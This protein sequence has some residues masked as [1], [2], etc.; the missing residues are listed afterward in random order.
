MKIKSC[1][2]K[3]HVHVYSA[4]LDDDGF[5]FIVAKLLCCEWSLMYLF[6]HYQLVLL[7]VAQVLWGPQRC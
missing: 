3:L 1:P 5:I 4:V 7:V 6:D 2:T